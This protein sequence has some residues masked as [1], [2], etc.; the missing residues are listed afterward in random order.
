LK[1]LFKRILIWLL[2]LCLNTQLRSQSYLQTYDLI[3]KNKTFQSTERTLDSLINEAVNNNNYIEAAK[4]SQTIFSNLYYKEKNYTKAIKYAH[5]EIEN[6]EKLNL[7][8]K[9]LTQ[10]TYNLGLANYRAKNYNISIQ[11]HFRVI[12]A[13]NS[14]TLTTKS[15]LEIGRNYYRLGEFYKA[16]EFYHKGITQ[17]EERKELKNLINK[18]IALVR[19]YNGMR[20][21][22][23]QINQLI[24]LKKLE[25][26][27]SNVKF[28]SR[29]ELTLNNF[30]ANYYNH[31]L[32][33]NFKKSR[34]YY[35]KN[36]KLA[37]RYNDSVFMC[38]T[39]NNLGDLYN[40]AKRDSALYY[41]KKTQIYCKEK[42]SDYYSYHQMS[43]AYLN[44]GELDIALDYINKSILALSESK[45]DFFS[46][47]AE[48]FKNI[49]DKLNL[50]LAF[51]RKA[52]ILL[53][54]YQKDGNIVHV[55]QALKQL[56]LI[57]TFIDAI[58]NNASEEQSQ[59]HWRKEASKTYSK[60]ILCSNILK[61][62]K[63]AFYFNE[64]S[65]ALLLTE[66]ILKNDVASS[67]PKP[68][69]K[70]EQ[71]FKKNILTLD[72]ELEGNDNSVLKDSLFDL[73]FEYQK[74]SD[75]LKSNFPDYY[76]NKS[77]TEL[78]ALNE[79]KKQ[80]DNNTLVISYNWDTSNNNLH[81]L[82]FS[83]SFTKSFSLNNANKIKDAISIYRTLLSRPHETKKDIENFQ[84]VAY[85]LFK[86]LFPIAIE[87]QLKDKHILIIP[88]ADLQNIP[89][90]AL[91]TNKNSND[92]LIKSNSISYAY[93][94]SFLLHNQ[95]AKRE[96]TTD[97]V[98][99]APVTFNYENLSNLNK[100]EDE[101]TAI[102][103]SIGGD[104]YLKAEADKTTFL[105]HGS[106]SK[107][108]HL[109]T[110]AEVSSDPWVAF[111]DTSLKLH[112]LYTHKINADLVVLSACNTAVG[113]QF[114]GEGVFSLSRGFFYSGANTVMS[115]HWSVNDKSTATI[116]TTF[117]SNLKDGKSKSEA[118]RNAQLSYLNNH[119]LT[120]ASPYYWAPFVLVG[121]YNNVPIQT[122]YALYIFLAII[123]I[124]IFLF[125]LKR[126]KVI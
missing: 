32:T 106:Q 61:R 88:D 122:N 71:A 27:K 13:N 125:I 102:Q 3:T 110:H 83:K 4:L 74:F 100:S 7:K 96:T 49:S 121:D 34:N 58:E 95:A 53:K 8:S 98:G 57:D 117:Y 31:P 46:P 5:I 89:F 84:Q 78:Y 104:T 22:E 63:L 115:S 9:D 73:K 54:A 124:A 101:L 70:K 6:Y 68:I 120:Q 10:A 24:V 48:D 56:Q 43:Y 91:I 114:Q 79:V 59:L 51:D 80:L 25:H 37:T 23:G 86:S 60:A 67:L 28:S 38:A 93:S 12:T 123:F 108:V 33:Y 126:K 20:S 29:Q 18:Y 42:D 11:C 66:S 41:L 65:K 113:E 111:S 94:M 44:R 55:E 69:L 72:N 45:N 16:E 36:L 35:L 92:Y 62:K 30:L 39:S 52:E 2:I 82:V 50:I 21:Y 112:E 1:S 97:F 116:M 99:F 26:L 81:V 15:Y 75:S 90:E 103:S 85:T 14:E 64:K 118:L 40:V 17:L 107:I 87:E 19:V 77:K 105:K 109:A 119:E 76:S 47:S